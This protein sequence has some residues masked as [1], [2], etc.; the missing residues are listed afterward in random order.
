MMFREY[1]NSTVTAKPKFQWK[2]NT[3]K[4]VEA[5]GEPSHRDRVTGSFLE[6]LLI[7]I[8]FGLFFLDKKISKIY[9]EGREESGYQ[10][11]GRLRY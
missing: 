5:L 4:P 10:W 11:E 8:S 2:R 7:L 6:A 9:R 3:Q 1:N